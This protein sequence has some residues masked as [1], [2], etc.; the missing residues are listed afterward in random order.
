MERYFLRSDKDNFWFVLISDKVESYMYKFTVTENEPPKMYRYVG[1][2]PIDLSTFHE[3]TDINQFSNSL[4]LYTSL[5]TCLTLHYQLTNI[6]IVTLKKISYCFVIP[7]KITTFVYR[8]KTNG[9]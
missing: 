5:C 7:K 1:N 3:L 2:E 4:L 6:N 8:N 9:L